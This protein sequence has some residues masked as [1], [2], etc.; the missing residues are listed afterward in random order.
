MLGLE[1]I[2]RAVWKL[3]R[4]YLAI[5]RDIVEREM[6][7]KNHHNLS[8]NRVIVDTQIQT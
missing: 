1:V 5:I 3:T 6:R 4:E 2:L 7:V 8:V